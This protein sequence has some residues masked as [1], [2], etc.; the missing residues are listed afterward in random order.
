MIHGVVLSPS[1]SI[2][3]FGRIVITWS[4]PLTGCAFARRQLL[5]CCDEA[6][7]RLL[8]GAAARELLPGVSGTPT[9]VPSDRAHDL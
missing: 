7:T 1:A 6:R 9:G 5:K 8:L 4:S 2:R 3:V